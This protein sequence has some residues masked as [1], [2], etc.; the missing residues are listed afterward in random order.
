MNGLKLWTRTHVC[1]HV[2]TQMG[3]TVCGWVGDTMT[4][5]LPKNPKTP[6][7]PQINLGVWDFEIN[8]VSLWIVYT[9]RASPTFIQQRCVLAQLYLCWMIFKLLRTFISWWNNDGIIMPQLYSLRA[10]QPEM[11]SPIIW[12]TVNMRLISLKIALHGFLSN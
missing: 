11:W 2:T 12:I 1:T 3:D 8:D 9:Q 5:L 6:Q 10:T 4:P 7:I